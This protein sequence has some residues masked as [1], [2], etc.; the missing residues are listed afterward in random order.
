[1]LGAAMV[2]AGG[3]VASAKWIR[4]TLASPAMVYLGRVSYPLYLWHWP[5][6]VLTRSY[7]WD[8]PAP[9]VD[10]LVV[11]LSLAL[12]VLTYELFERRVRAFLN[13]R[14]PP[15]RVLLVGAAATCAC[16]ASA[17]LLGA[18]ARFGWGYSPVEQAL[19]AVRTDFPE[20]GCMGQWPSETLLA[21]CY[22][23]SAAPSILLW[24]DS[25]A[26]QW[27]P[28]L[29]P[30]AERVGANLG[31]YTDSACKPLPLLQDQCWGTPAK[32]IGLL[33]QWQQ[34]RHLAGMVIAARWAYGIGTPSPT[35]SERVRHGSSTAPCAIRTTHFG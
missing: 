35:L 32:V 7:R 23:P 13:E 26:K 17:A 4:W 30:A 20:T 27:G 3:S 34:D 28:A 31:I 14:W 24:G 19:A 10:S 25:H 1:M 9:A 6:L 29:K 11:G 16:L 5:L 33:P 12:A 8:E 15:R 2:I 21:R 18:W 22:P